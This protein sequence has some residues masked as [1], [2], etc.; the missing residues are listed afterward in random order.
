M[1]A[2]VR[3][4][5]WERGSWGRPLR[6]SAQRDRDSSP[7]GGRTAY[8]FERLIT[9]WSEARSG[10]RRELSIRRPLH[11]LRRNL[12][13][14]LS[15]SA[16]GFNLQ[17][18]VNALDAVKR[19]KGIVAANRTLAYA[20]AAY[21]WAARRELVP[22]NPLKGIERPGREVARDRVLS[23]DE[24][25]AI[26]R[27]SATLAPVRQAFVRV[28]MLTLQRLG[29]CSR[30]VGQSWTGPASQQS[31]QYQRNGPRTYDAFGALG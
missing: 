22:A 20:R 23:A 9:D 16:N 30:C 31:G 18:A 13:D 19:E 5:C 2:A 29:E 4:R 24:L 3:G 6:R 12:P 1:R 7:R 10:D 17:D 15:R 14:W 21:S 25:G 26:W 8:T 11:A 27:A 28:L